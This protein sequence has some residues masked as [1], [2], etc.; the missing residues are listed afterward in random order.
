LGSDTFVA[1]QV[2]PPGH[3]DM[4]L[5]SQTWV[6]VGV[7]PWIWAHTADAWQSVCKLQGWPSGTGPGAAHSVLSNVSVR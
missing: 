7:G 2:V 1:E 5:G 6:H 4:P 3:A